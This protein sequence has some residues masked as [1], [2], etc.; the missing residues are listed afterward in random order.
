M[1]LTTFGRNA[2]L[3]TALLW[4]GALAGG[5]AQAAPTTTP[6]KPAAQ[7][8]PVLPGANPVIWKVGRALLEESD[9]TI[10][11]RTETYRDEITTAQASQP[12]APGHKAPAKS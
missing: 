10:N 5:T 11:L 2:A 8:A 12:L 3:V 6:V 1:P 4:G 9:A 7:I